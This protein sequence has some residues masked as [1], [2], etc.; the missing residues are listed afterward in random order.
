MKALKINILVIVTIICSLSVSAQNFYPKESE[1][2]EYSYNVKYSGER[3][4]IKD[5]INAY[6]AEPEDEHTG[7]I[8]KV[9]QRYLNNEPQP[10]GYKITVDTKNGFV[11]IES[12]TQDEGRNYK[13]IVEFCYWNCADG[14]HKIFCKSSFTYL[15]GKPEWGW[16]Y[17]GI[18][19]NV[20]NNNIRKMTHINSEDMGVYIKTERDIYGSGFDG[21]NY[22]Y[23]NFETGE[24]KTLSEAEYN[25]WE[26]NLPVV[27]YSLPRVG[28][29]I[30]ATIHKPNGDK[31]VKLTW[32]G[33]SF[34]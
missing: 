29:D 21:K 5:F 28:K 23:E 2:D 34:K 13:T 32:D 33:Y 17:D 15:N 16:Q 14:K 19:F 26:E 3:P 9:W 6:V 27:T 12:T 22:Y 1:Y 10:D 24:K 20:Y 30:T 31:Q 18:S 4:T 8:N 7:M 11:C 25:K